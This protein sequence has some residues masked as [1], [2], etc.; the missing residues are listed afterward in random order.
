MSRKE[1]GLGVLALGALAIWI[2]YQNRSAASAVAAALAA[3]PASTGA[4]DAND[5]TNGDLNDGDGSF[6]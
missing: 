6:G 1:I 4:S 3:N 2:Y 5:A